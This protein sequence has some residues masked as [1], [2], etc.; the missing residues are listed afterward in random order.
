MF[1]DQNTR[2]K[3]YTFSIPNIVGTN[4]RFF[5]SNMSEF[6]QKSHSIVEIKNDQ[7]NMCFSFAFVLGLAHLKEDK[8]LYERF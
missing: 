1:I 5:T 7:N 2:L 4:T 8:S 6:L 3:V